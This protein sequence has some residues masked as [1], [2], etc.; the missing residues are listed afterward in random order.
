MM[1]LLRAIG[2]QLALVFSEGAPPGA[3]GS[4]ERFREQSQVES[5]VNKRF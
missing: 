4:G 3:G 2:R 5:D 1:K